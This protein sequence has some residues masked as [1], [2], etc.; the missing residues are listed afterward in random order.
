MKLDWQYS[1]G[2]MS[3]SGE[4]DTLSEYNMPPAQDQANGGRNQGNRFKQ[5]NRRGRRDAEKDR[6]TASLCVFAFS[7]VKPNVP[8]SN[9]VYADT[10]SAC[11]AA[12]DCCFKGFAPFASLR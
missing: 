8:C 2:R 3:F 11:S 12:Q 6:T 1:I 5:S 7:A 10:R 4:A 9:T